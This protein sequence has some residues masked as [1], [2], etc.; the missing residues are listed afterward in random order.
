MSKVHCFKLRL[1]YCAGVFRT[2]WTA[3]CYVGSK[4]DWLL[5]A[6]LF[7]TSSLHSLFP[8]ATP[9]DINSSPVWWTRYSAV[10]FLATVQADLYIYG[11]RKMFLNALVR[12]L[13]LPL[14]EEQQ[15]HP[16]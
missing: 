13:F 4:W 11:T 7:S 8:F 6:L 10:L 12:H 2:G 14:D 5:W 16:L 9:S 1:S 15:N 3:G